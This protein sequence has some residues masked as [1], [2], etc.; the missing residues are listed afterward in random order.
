MSDGKI[1]LAKSWMKSTGHWRE[2]TKTAYQLPKKAR[3][4]QEPPSALNQGRIRGR[5]S[6]QIFPVICGRGFTCLGCTHSYDTH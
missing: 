3:V 4:D 5:D 6:R 1:Q 2:W